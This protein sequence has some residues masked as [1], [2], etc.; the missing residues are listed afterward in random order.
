VRHQ[1]QPQQQQQQRLEE[2][3]Q[4]PAPLQAGLHWRSS[5]V[6]LGD[7][8]AQQS[9]GEGQLRRLQL[10]LVYQQQLQRQALLQHLA[11]AA[12]LPL[13]LRLAGQL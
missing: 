12:A 7:A 11:V 10:R 9:L 1:Q 5:R 6:V 2:V 13:R 3:V 4:L 8:G